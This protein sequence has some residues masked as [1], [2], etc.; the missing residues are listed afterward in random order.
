SVR[1]WWEVNPPDLPDPCNNPVGCV[2]RLYG[3]DITDDDVIFMSDAWNQRAYRYA[4][5]GT[6]LSTFGAAQLGGDNRGVVVNEALDRVYIVDAEHSQIDMFTQAGT[7]ISSFSSEGTGPGQFSGGGREADIDKDGN[8]WVGDFGGFEVEKFSPTGQPLLRAPDPARKPPL[9]FL[10]QPRDVAVDDQ[11]GE[12]WV[13]DAWN[14]RFV[15]FSATGA[16]MGTWGTRGP[17]GPFDMNYPRSIAIDPVTRR[18]WVANERGHHIQVYTYPT[19]ATGS[20]TYVRQIGQIARDDVE[21]NHFRWPVDIEFYTQPSGRR[22][23]VIGDRMAASVKMFDANTYQEITKPV[24]PDPSDPEN[25]LIPVA[26]HGTAI[27]PATGNIYVINPSADRVEVFNQSGDP[28]NVTTDTSGNPTNRFGSSGTADGQ[29]RD[30]VDAVI[31]N[32]VLYVVDE[33]IGRIQAFTLQGAFLGKW[34]GSFDGGAYDFRNPAGVDADAQGRLYVTDSQNDRIQVFNPAA[35]RTFEI[36]QPSV[37]TVSSPAQQAVLPLAPVTFQGTATDN[38]SVAN[39]ELMIQ[40]LQTSKW[41]N[42]TNSSWESAVAGS[43][44]PAIAAAW[45]STAAPAT[46]VSWRSTFSGVSAGGTYL[47]YVRTRDASGNVSDVNVRTFGMPGTSPPAPPPAPNFDTIRPDGRVTF[48]V[49]NQQLPLTTVNVVGTATDNVGVTQVRVALR[50]VATGRWWT[51]S[52]ST[53][54]ST[55]IR[56][57]DAV[58]EAPGA[59]STGWSWSWTPRVAGN[60]RLN[61]QIRDAEGNVDGSP[62]NTPFTITGEAPDTIEPDTTITAPAEGATVP[63]GSVQIQGT[64]VDDKV[65]AAVRVGI[66]DTATNLWWNG[67]GWVE[68]ETTVAASLQS[69]N[70]AT[71]NWTYAFA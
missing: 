20:P 23:A 2:P 59:T 44:L 24:D 13:A 69:P 46:S 63:S 15:R 7:Y 35:A 68:P 21:P 39:V 27:D 58:V 25:P 43:P 64:A 60:Y 54:F 5:D 12:V 51:G 14:Q 31:S 29:F 45:T 66:R 70:A 34:G 55:T 8:L 42:S 28:V 1:N 67:T 53:G 33:S 50:D 10:G 48:P 17:G 22:V 3:I 52:G 18:I 16:H 6:W 62:P 61:V 37:P 65:V 11:T 32:G 26:N 56:Y 36:Q 9:G 40:N 57:W 30:P 19:S 71:T 47:V 41:W 49:A 38:A 4:K